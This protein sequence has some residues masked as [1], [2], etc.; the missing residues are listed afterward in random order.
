M[1]SNQPLSGEQ[2]QSKVISFL[3]FPLCVGVVLIHVGTNTENC[4]SHP[5]FDSVQYLFAQ[6]L[7]RV[8]VPLFFA[9]SGF[10]FFNKNECFT[11]SNYK[12]KLRKRFWNLLIPYLFWNF[13]PILYL[14]LGRF[15]GLGSLYGIGFTLVDWIKPFWNNYTPPF[16]GEAIAS[17]PINIP[18]WYIRDLMV[19]VI[20]SPIIYFMTRRFR[21]VF[22]VILCVLWITNCWFLL[23]GVNITALFFFSLGAYF[24][25]CKKNFSELLRPH[26]AILGI[27]YL[28]LIIPLFITKELTWNPLRRVGI[29]FGM[30]FWISL[31]SRLVATRKW[32]INSFLS[33]SSFFIFAYHSVVLLLIGDIVNA[34]FSTDVMCT[35]QYLSTAAVIVLVGLSIYYILKKWFPRFT[36]FITGGR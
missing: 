36:A 14:L 12:E 23:T 30:A 13:M 11:F 20:L 27:L 19:T 21:L 22:V 6:I 24:S 3:R 10:L 33:E 32:R 28:I 2:L 18:F 9:F 35:I 1:P 16:N 34:S 15:L 5:L 29:L 7:A 25:I 31:V 17:Y 4:P 26:T 8:A